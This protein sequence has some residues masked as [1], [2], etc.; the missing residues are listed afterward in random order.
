MKKVLAK[1]Y[2]YLV[3]TIAAFLNAVSLHLFTTPAQLIPGGVSGLSS[4][5]YYV[6]NIPMSIL[7]FS[8]NVP[9][10]ICAIIFV[11]GDFTI[12]TIYATLI[13]SMFL[14]IFPEN[15]VFVDT[16]GAVLNAI[17]GGVLVGIAMYMASVVNGSNGGTEIVGKIVH[18]FHPEIDISSVI[19]S[20][21]MIILAMGG[22]VVKDLLKIIYSLVLAFSA[23]GMMETLN[24]GFDRPL[25][26]TIITTKGDE[27]AEQITKAFLRGV[28]KFD[29][30]NAQGE[31]TENSMLIVVVQYRQ[32]ARLRR[33]LRN[34]G[35]N[36]SYVKE[37]ETVF[38][39]PNF[40]KPYNTGEQNK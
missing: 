27:L 31:K 2:E 10:L 33:I 25:R 4:V 6:T 5:L 19:I 11:K 18:K 1:A 38:S 12:K 7:Y 36:F 13:C 21:N 8:L 14:E 26:F 9:L 40:N 32:S 28:T 15:L 23:S 29:V 20:C 22:L 17:G 37:V 30:Y 3:I 39:R 34:A 35:S 16:H 24:R